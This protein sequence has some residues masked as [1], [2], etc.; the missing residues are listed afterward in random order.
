[1]FMSI[2]TNGSA[3]AHHHRSMYVNRLI[4]AGL[5]LL[6]MGCQTGQP[7]KTIQADNGSFMGLWNTYAHCQ[8]ATDLDQLKQDALVLTTAATRSA[9]PVGFVVP[10]PGKIERMVTTPSARLAVDV[11][12]MAA[13]CTLKAGQAAVGLQK[14]DVARPLLQSVAGFHGSDYAYYSSQA[15]SLLASLDNPIVQVSLK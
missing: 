3:I 1:M 6:V 14:F 8:S 10:L 15:K 9:S 4:V 5:A 7:V 11:K 12:A 2:M 13:S